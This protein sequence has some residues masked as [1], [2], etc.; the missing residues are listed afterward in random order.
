MVLLGTETPGANRGIFSE[1]A[2]GETRTSNPLVISLMR[3][4]PQL[5]NDKYI[6][7]SYIF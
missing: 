2:D 3:S 1:D 5:S 6:M 7:K 4:Q